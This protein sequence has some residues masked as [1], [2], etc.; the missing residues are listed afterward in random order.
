MLPADPSLKFARLVPGDGAA[1][2]HLEKAVPDLGLGVADAWLGKGLGKT[3]ARAVML[4]AA[5]REV[6]RVELIVVKENARARRVYEGL[7]FTTCGE[8]VDDTDGLTDRNSLSHTTERTTHAEPQTL[9]KPT[10]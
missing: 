8:F 9:S 4:E 3:L 7:S 5:R 1:L 10:I 6:D 2:C